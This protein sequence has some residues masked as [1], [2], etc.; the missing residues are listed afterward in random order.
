MS[1]WKILLTDGLKEKGQAILRVAPEVGSVDDQ[2]GISPDKLKDLISQYDAVIVRGRTKM[3]SEVFAFSA[4]LKVV[5][6]AGVGVDNIDLAAAQA[7]S[8]TIVNSPLATTNAVAEHTL[9]L[10]LSLVRFVP[11]ADTAMKSGQWIKKQLIGTEL[12]GKVLGIIGMGRIGTA[13]G[14]RAAA[15][16]MQVLG[17]DPFLPA[18]RIQERGAAPVGLSEI[19]SRSDII[20][21]HLPLSPDTR[22]MLDGQAFGYMKRGVRL[23]CAARGGIIDETALLAAI[24]SGQVSGAALDVF[25]VEPPGL[26]ALVAHPS[27]VTTPHIGAQTKEAQVR[28]A[29]DIASEVLAA[30]RD[31]PL[32]WKIV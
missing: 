32:R 1:D 21:L 23:V 31:E 6:R 24:E 27:V 30:L 13:V 8:I 18:E 10:M 7:R 11:A 25:G 12:D 3:T 29:E 28:A 22:N 2:N 19:Y 26:T 20:S 9:A 5:G 15:F 16:G 14:T 17:F 4:N